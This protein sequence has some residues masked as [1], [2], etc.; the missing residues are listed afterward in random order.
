[1]RGRCP[2]LG[3]TLKPSRDVD[4]ITENVI[5]LDQDVSEIDPDPKQHTP[6]LRDALVAF[7]HHRLHS[8][9]TF[10]R[11]DH[12]G[13]LKQHAVI[14]CLHEATAMFCHEG[15]GNLAVFAEGA[16]GAYLVEPH[17]PR[18]ARHVSRDNGRQPASNPNWLLL[19]HDRHHPARNVAN[20]H[21][22][23]RDGP[24]QQMEPWLV[25]HPR[26]P[27]RGVRTYRRAATS[28]QRG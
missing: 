3:D 10:D 22:G 12:R 23:L 4:A 16:G 26:R 19:L 8:H 11:I 5:A 2:R 17:E 18:V 28:A 14:R 15:V 24:R 7:G 6:V 20:R 13:K 1:M 27:R 9:C 21:S 25:R